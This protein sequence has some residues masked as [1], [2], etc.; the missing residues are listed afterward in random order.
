MSG[1]VGERGLK[2]VMNDK[3]EIQENVERQANIN[4]AL[5]L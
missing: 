2:K 1:I 4:T 5:E 3:R